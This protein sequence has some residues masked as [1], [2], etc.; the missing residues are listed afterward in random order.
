M[1]ISISASRSRR[2][3]AS[4]AATALAVGGLVALTPS[5]AQAKTATQL[6][7]DTPIVMA[8]CFGAPGTATGGVHKVN[9]TDT[10]NYTIALPATAPVKDY[11][12]RARYG[13][14]DATTKK[15]VFGFGFMFCSMSR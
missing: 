6:A 14:F 2:I 9:T 3:L 1:S 15:M 7:F 11:E 12:F 5:A 10:Q 13:Y 8:G 4:A